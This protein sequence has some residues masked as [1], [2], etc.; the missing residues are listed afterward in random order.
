[1]PAGRPQKPLALAEATGRTQQ[2]RARYSA[3]I[4]ASKVDGKQEREPIG[5]PPETLDFIE[6]A[7]WYELTALWWWLDASDRVNLEHYCKLFAKV[8]TGVMD[9]AVHN[10]CMRLGDKLGA[11][12]ATRCKIIEGRNL[13][14]G[15]DDDGL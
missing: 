4:E 8:R 2:N 13:V 11:S 10:A 9:M 12:Y 7:I 1:M 3:R 6:M 5:L 15:D 14:G